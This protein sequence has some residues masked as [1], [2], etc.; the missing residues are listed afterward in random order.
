MNC[1]PVQPIDLLSLSDSSNSEIKFKK[2]KLINNIFC[3]EFKA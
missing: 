3:I 1:L 2:K